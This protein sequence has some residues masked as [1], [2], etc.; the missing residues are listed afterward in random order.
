[1]TGDNDRGRVGNVTAEEVCRVWGDQLQPV[2]S[3]LVSPRLSVST[4]EFLSAV[5]L[6]TVETVESAGLIGLP[7]P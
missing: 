6:P 2:P 5:G 4:R 1:M 3:E 7:P